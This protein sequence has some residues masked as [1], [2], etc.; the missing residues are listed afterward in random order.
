MPWPVLGL[1]GKLLFSFVAILLIPLATLGLLGP[2]IYA[3]SFEQEI[4]D[5]TRKTI[6]LVGQRIDDQISD[7]DDALSELLSRPE[8]RAYLRGQRTSPS[9]EAIAEALSR[10]QA[11][12]AGLVAA[13]AL[14]ADDGDFLSPQLV[15]ITRAPLTE[16][17]WYRAALRRP[18]SIVLVPRPI[19]RNLRAREGYGADDV[20]TMVK[21]LEA[22]SHGLPA[23][24]VML[25]LRLKAIE[26]LFEGLSLSASGF[27]F[28]TDATGEMV[29]TPV[30]PIVHRISLAWFSPNKDVAVHVIAGKSYQL[31]SRRSEY[32]GWRTVGVFSLAEALRQ[33]D[34]LR[35]VSV[36]S[37]ALALTLAVLAAWGLAGS[38]VKP[39]TGLQELMKAV[40]GGDLTVRFDGRA[41]DEVGRLGRGFNT[42]IEEIRHLIE[43]VHEV[44]QSKREAEL[45]VLQEQIKPHFLYNTLDT[46]HWMA[47]EHGAQDI[48]ALVHALTRL[49]RIGLSKGRETITLR[50][51]CDHVESY[52]F[53]QK[54]RYEDQFDYAL[55]VPDDL[56]ETPV[57]R[58]LLQP[59]VENALYHGVKN[60]Q[61]SGRIEV[62]VRRDEAFLVL[63]IE[64]NGPG[65]PLETR[66]QINRRLDSGEGIDGGT[67]S[68]LFNVDG[69]LKLAWG[70]RYGIT[71]LPRAEGGTVVQVRHP[72]IEEGGS[73]A[74][75]N[76]DRG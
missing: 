51:E 76:F 65:M 28:I 67:A 53:I 6:E 13:V 31:H 75:A 7:L 55:R 29:Y 73:H 41:D 9:R 70:R 42:M 26:D 50:Q 15:P 72:W 19:G 57:L 64:D 69:R 62:R 24:A 52:L 48:A 23:G 44:Y 30:N 54:V 68:G 4:N 25:D 36:A 16:E 32:T 47:E 22:P 61:K 17:P 2:V 71:L 59:L 21:S 37:T 58:L 40:E 3:Q 12:R 74:L 66:E 8:V 1:R 27:F 33:V 18:G 5:H 14:I 56:L 63:E 49:F 11:V 10:F 34:L 45:Q 60:G 46:I 43:E 35:W 39:I 20:V 38:L